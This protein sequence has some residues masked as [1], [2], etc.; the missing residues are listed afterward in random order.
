MV[1]WEVQAEAR[2]QLL[3]FELCLRVPTKSERLTAKSE[4]GS[5]R[6]EGHQHL[7]R[8]SGR[9]MGTTAP[10]APRHQ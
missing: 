5:R 4:T 10:Q 8:C 7:V 1:R 6:E 9:C 2:C 3:I